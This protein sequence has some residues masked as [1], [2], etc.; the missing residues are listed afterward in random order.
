MLL[1]CKLLVINMFIF[2]SFLPGKVL[3][4]GGSIANF[5]NVAATFKVNLLLETL[6]KVNFRTLAL[7]TFLSCNY[8]QK[9]FYTCLHATETCLFT[10]VC[11]EC[12]RSLSPH[13][14]PSVVGLQGI[15]RA[16]KDYQTPLKEHEVTIFVRRGGPN[17]QEG[18]RVMG[19]V[20]EC[21][22]PPFIYMW[23]LV[24]MH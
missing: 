5:T 1:E 11:L 10:K 13:S 4:I 19:E 6:H 24:D 20:G 23:I 7:S 12:S 2:L 18:L 22:I 3:I 8:A 17:Y 16:I 15:V 14:W 21:C 9:I